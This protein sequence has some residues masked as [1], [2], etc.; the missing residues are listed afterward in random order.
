MEPIFSRSLDASSGLSA[1]TDARLA[2]AP[3]AIWKGGT[4]I[5]VASVALLDTGFV[6]G[7][8]SARDPDHDRCVEAWRKFRGRLCSVD[9]VLVESAHVLRKIK[10]GPAAAVGFVYAARAELVPCT[11][12]RANRA[13]ELMKRYENVPMDFVDALLVEAAEEYGIRDVLTLDRRG[14]ETYRVG[15]ERF[16]IVC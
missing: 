12:A 2:V 7:L 13:L 10:G 16:R 4:R 8:V 14:F 9:G 3:V 1:E 6:I 5:A 15:R 11:E